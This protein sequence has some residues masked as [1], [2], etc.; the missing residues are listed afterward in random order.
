MDKIFSRKRITIPKVFVSKI[1]EKKE[2]IIR[3]KKIKVILVLTIAIFTMVSIVKG[4][5]PII[6]RLCIDA[7]KKEATLVSN[8]KATEVMSNYT[9]E[10]MVTIYRDENNNVTM[11]KSNIIA[12]NEITSDVAVKIQEEFESNRESTMHLRAR[13]FNRYK[14]FIRFRARYSNKIINFRNSFDKSKKRI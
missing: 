14:N 7:S 1:P 2:D 3:R 11:I 4:I 12:I 13:K 6:N 8:K 10:D 9:Y 5:N